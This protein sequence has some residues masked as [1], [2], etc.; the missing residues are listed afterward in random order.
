M[1]V[2]VRKE[3]AASAS[4]LWRLLTDFRMP[5]KH[6]GLESF[7][8]EGEGV[9]HVRTLRLA[10]GERVIERLDAFD[11]GARRL[12]VALTVE[13]A[14]IPWRDSECTVTVFE[15]DRDRCVMECVVRFDPMGVEASLAQRRMEGI[16]LGFMSAI[17]D[18]LTGAA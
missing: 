15:K 5:P 18:E 11:E 12:R 3:M 1:Q 10:G 4:A 13:S 2:T 7:T 9:G 16:Y 14:R 6:L 8:I 17:E